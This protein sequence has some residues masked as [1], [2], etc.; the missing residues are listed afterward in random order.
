MN[1]TEYLKSY[2]T[3]EIPATINTLS[4]LQNEVEENG[5]DYNEYRDMIQFSEGMLHA[6]QDIASRLYGFP[7]FEV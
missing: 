3:K 5:G 2:L 1:V 7:K 6:Y 4:S